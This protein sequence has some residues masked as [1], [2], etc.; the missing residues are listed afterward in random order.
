[1]IN[2]DNAKEA[3]IETLGLANIK[4]NSKNPW[5]IKVHDERLYSRLLKE[6][7]LALG[8][9]YMDGW[10]DCE[11]IDVLTEK[12]IRAELHKQV[13]YDK[14]FLFQMMLDYILNPQTKEK[15][16]KVAIEHYDIGNPLYKAMLDR[17]MNY[18]CG[19]WK[20]ARS[21]NTAQEDKLEMICQ[22]LQ[23][24][25]GMRLLDIGCGFGAMAAYAA[26]NYGVEVVGITI[27]KEQ[28]TLAQKKCA[29]LPIEIRLC[30]YRDVEETFDR[31]VSIGMFEHV[32]CKNYSTFMKR[33][34]NNLNPEGL[35]LLHT[36][37]NN[38]SVHTGS[39]WITKYIFPN[40][41]LPSIKQIGESIEGLFVMED[42]HNFGPDYAKTLMAWHQ[43]F[44][45][46]WDKIED[47]YDE[48]FKRMWNFYLLYC[49][50]I[51]RA[52]HLQLW[53]V[54]LSKDGLKEGVQVRD[55]QK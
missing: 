31:V 37:G 54:V 39:P 17:Q 13:K 25:P 23:L 45:K 42:W 1:M 48:R 4:I 5:D 11:Q 14:K 6:G 47:K 49:A 51:F 3:V 46:N 40:S 10:W 18:S 22:K 8:E 9:S 43:N 2:T 21:L 16:K 28:Q 15:S 7:E 38:Q 35:F 24:E 53:Q 50:G 41:M 52:R 19:Y 44:N 33:V 30:D 55:L 32:G 29:G 12:L 20:Y 34:Y 36:I 27:S 26:K